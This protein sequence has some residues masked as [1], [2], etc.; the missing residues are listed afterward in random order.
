MKRTFTTQRTKQDE[1]LE[2]IGLGIVVVGLI[3]M[4]IAFL[5]ETHI[6]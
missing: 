5:F 1:R 3:A 6:I 2:Y 4:T